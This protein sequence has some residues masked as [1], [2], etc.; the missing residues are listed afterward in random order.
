MVFV[1]AWILLV[2][3]P[4]AHWVFAFDAADG[5]TKGG[6]IANKLHAL[7]FAGGTA[8]E[9]NSGAA[10]LALALVV[11]RRVGWKRDPFRPHNLPAVA[12]DLLC[13]GVRPLRGDPANLAAFQAARFPA[14]QEWGTGMG[15]KTGLAPAVLGW[16]LSPFSGPDRLGG[17]FQTAHRRTNGE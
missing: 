5:S 15:W 9:I 10:A 4:I 17:R 8:V 6:W 3:A 14:P 11:G 12:D 2:Y 16:C 13:P 1:P 7:D